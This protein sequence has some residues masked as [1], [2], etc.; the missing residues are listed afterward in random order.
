MFGFS[1]YNY[2][3]FTRD[4]LVK[5]ME[6]CRSAGGPEPG[7]KA[8][9]FE[10]RTLDGD[11]IRLS[12]FRGDRN[13]VVTFGSATCPMTAG[14][15]GG[16]NKL[17]EVYRGEDVRFLFVYVREAHPGEEIPAHQ[18]MKDKVRAAQ[19]LQAEEQIE[20]PIVVDEL[21]G[22]IHRRYGKLPNPTYLIDK[23]GR[24]AFRCLWTQ[25]GVVEDALEA[26]LE[27]QRERG[28][29]H[30]VVNSGED[31][32][33]PVSYA[34][35]HAYRALERGGQR[36]LADFRE[37]MG[38]PGRAFLTASRVVRPVAMNPGKAIAAAALAAGALTAGLLAGKKLRQQRW[39]RDLPYDVHQAPTQRKPKR[40]ATGT[41]DYEPVGI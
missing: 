34:V 32:S 2:E 15:I 31:R 35:I 37:S 17:C 21:S 7:E 9:D 10:G 39:Q 38:L 20:M 18:E 28:V 27:R 23:S 8:P 40:T 16:M 6:A 24:V 4:L 26:L 41:D 1:S 30:A 5:D 33:M 19:I 11:K 13:V 22:P 14:S 25:P 29:D 12:D 36:S 3:K